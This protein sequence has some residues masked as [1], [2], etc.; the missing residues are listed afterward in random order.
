MTNVLTTAIIVVSLVAAACGLVTTL[1]DRPMGRT[2]LAAFAVLELLL[3]GQVVTASIAL[4]RGEGPA[5]PV[6]FVGYLLGILL[7]PLAG[8]GWGRLERSRW[9]PAVLVAAGL[10]VAVMT[11]RMRQIWTGTG[12]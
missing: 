7:I 1:R 11:E 4:A 9:G 10:S 3:V 12:G 5:D 2:D 8:V 6:T